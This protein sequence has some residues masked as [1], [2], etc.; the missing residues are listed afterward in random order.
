MV[1]GGSAPQRRQERHSIKKDL[2][3]GGMRDSAKEK[4]SR[5]GGQPGWEVEIFL[6]SVLSPAKVAE[7]E[8]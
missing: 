7:C 8:F 2:R 1:A 3:S 6:N 5:G 4:P